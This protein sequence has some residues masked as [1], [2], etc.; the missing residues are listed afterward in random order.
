M[1][2]FILSSVDV[3]QDKTPLQYKMKIKATI[4][5]QLPW[6]KIENFIK[7]L[8]EKKLGLVEGK[9][10]IR[11]FLKVNYP[12]FESA[13][14]LEI[15]LKKTKQE[16]LNQIKEIIN[17]Y[18]IPISIKGIFFGLFTKISEPWEVFSK[19][20]TLYICG[21]KVSPEEN[22]IDWSCS[23]AYF[24]PNR[25]LKSSSFLKIDVELKKYKSVSDV[26]QVL[27][28]GISNLIILNS[29]QEIKSIVKLDGTYIGSGY[30]SG[31]SFLLGKI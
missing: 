23:P 20:T 27:F 24:P 18:P 14:I 7:S 11:T 22:P 28:N 12:S 16:F 26:E 19:D 2:N 3:F 30:D 8:S 17:I 10:K 6:K 21:S 4:K 15:D 5:E 13:F 29:L 9:E 25:C 1:V 31:D